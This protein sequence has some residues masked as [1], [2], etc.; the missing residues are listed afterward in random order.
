MQYWVF[1]VCTPDEYQTRMK[2]LEMLFSVSAHNRVV[3]VPTTLVKNENELLSTLNTY[4]SQGYEGIII[5]KPGGGYESKRSFNLMKLKPFKDTEAIVEDFIPGH[6]K[7]SGMVGALRGRLLA[8][9]F[10]DGRVDVGSGF[11]DAERI[12]MWDNKDRVIGQVFTL[13]YQEKTKHGVP[14]FPTFKHFRDL[15]F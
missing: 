5:R 3:L 14:R 10:G 1:D 11:S 4:I 8:P 6:G 15:R 7:L 2:Y 12:F 13:Q 9:E